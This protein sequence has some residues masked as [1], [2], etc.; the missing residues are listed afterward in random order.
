[1]ESLLRWIGRLA[2]VCGI[3]VSAWAGF[4]RLTG[5]FFAGGYPVGALL[6]AGMTGLLVACFCLLLVLTQR[7]RR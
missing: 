4:A 1:M 6:L 7:T 5:S 3:L 2:G